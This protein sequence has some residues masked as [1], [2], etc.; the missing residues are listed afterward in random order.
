[1]RIPRL[2]ALTLALSQALGAGTAWAN[3]MDPVVVNGGA[4]FNN[5]GNVLTIVNTPGAIINWGSFNIGGNET[6]RFVQQGPSSAVLNRILGQDPSTILGALQSNGHVFLVNPNGVVFGSGARVDV[7]GLI[8]SSLDIKNDDFRAGR[9]KFDSGSGNPGAVKNDGAITTPSGGRVY[10]IAPSV[11]NSGLISSPQ[12]EVLLAAGR[13]VQLVDSHNPDLHVVA[14]AP[15][16]PAVN[17]G[18]IISQGGSNG[19][20]G[21]LVN[22][23]GVVNADSAA[24]GENGRIVFKASDTTLLEAVSTTS[25]R[26]AGE[27]GTVHVLG[28]HVG[29][30]DNASIDASGRT[31]GGTVLVGG[32]YRGLNSSISN[33]S[34]AYVGAGTSIRADAT[35]SGNGGRVIVYSAGATRAYGQISARGGASSGNGGFAEVSG[36]DYLDYRGRTDLRAANGAAGTLLLDPND[37]TIQAGPAE[38]STVD[39]PG[40]TYTFSG[41]PAS[42]VITTT[43]LESQLG[44]GNVTV[45]TSAGTGGPLGGHITVA[46]AFGW[47]NSN[48]LTLDADNGISINGAITGNADGRLFLTSRGGSITQTAAIGTSYL[49]I[50]SAGSVNLN[51][52]ANMVNVLAAQV[53]SGDLSFTNGMSLT[54]GT[55]G[56]I[57]GISAGNVALHATSGQILQT[58]GAIITAN[59]ANFEADTVNLDEANNVGTISGAVTGQLPTFRSPA[60]GAVRSYTPGVNAFSFTNQGSLTVGSVAGRSGIT[61]ATGDITLSSNAGSLTLANAASAPNGG[62][63]LNAFQGGIT[64]SAN[65][66]AVTAYADGDISLTTQAQEISAGTSGATSAITINNTGALTV[67]AISNNGSGAISVTASGPLTVNGISTRSGAVTLSAGP[68]GAATDDLTVN[69]NITTQVDTG[70]AIETAGPVLLRA[71]DAIAINGTVAGNVTQQPHLNTPALPSISDCID[72]P[73]LAGCNQVLPSIEQCIAQPLTAGCVS[74]MPTIEQCTLN[75]GKPGC[76]AVLPSLQQCIAS[77][78]LAGCTAV[79]PPIQACVAQ[80]SAPGCSA[81][82]PSPQQCATNPSLAGCSAVLPTL[83]QCM[84]NPSLTGCSSVLPSF[85]QCMA[86]PSTPGCSTVLAPFNACLANPSGPGCSQLLPPLATCQLTPSVLGCSQVLELAFQAC[87]A[88][89]LAPGCSGILPSISTCVAQSSTRG[90]DAVLPTLSQCIGSPTLQGCSVRLPSLQMCAA[91]PATPGC[92]AVLPRPDF[93]GAH[94]GDPTCAIFNPGP[95]GGTGDAKNPISQTVDTTITLVNNGTGKLPTGTGGTS[96]TGGSTT[97]T[98]NPG[99]GDKPSTGPAGSENSGAKNEKPAT[100]LYCN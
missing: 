10:L 36:R 68:T 37:I 94:P 79:L 41:G 48:A 78:A 50:S 30:V 45:S 38:G 52:A 87:L 29:V 18:Q 88:N 44:L 15:A 85:Q 96:G 63:F 91:N 26:G 28:G 90:C 25:A 95:T 3:P 82:L 53:G 43:D 16:D 89:P 21:A 62:V 12:G 93:C 46:N 65:G 34:A 70:G 35:E 17:I 80:P 54:V 40:T 74:V 4:T 49:G 55:V 71:G 98:N 2:L 27:G 97:T 61:S 66:L 76:S 1:M 20:S 83:D 69:G 86:S 75:P 77:P 84:A 57:N 22:Q 81:V 51:G 24:V 92:E 42:S 39:W 11:E 58:S 5:N 8:A 100:K 64:G 59:A 47:T 23:R 33:A 9:L 13:Q 56:G 14:S 67:D 31:G 7:N 6:T 19:I 60:D 32:D 73:V 72:N 99:S